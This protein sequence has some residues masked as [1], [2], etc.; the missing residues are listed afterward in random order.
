MSILVQDIRKLPDVAEYDERMEEAVSKGDK[1]DRMLHPIVSHK[2][3][4]PV[5]AYLPGTLCRKDG[6]ETT[7]VYRLEEW[8]GPQLARV[9]LHCADGSVEPAVGST[10]I[11]RRRSQDGVFRQCLIGHVT[12]P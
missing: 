11:R 1:Y 2:I 10:L 9:T 3:P 7:A 6:R 8:V 4:L 12:S 5:G